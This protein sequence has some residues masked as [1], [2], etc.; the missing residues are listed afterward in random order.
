M[1]FYKLIKY[2]LRNGFFQNRFRLMAIILLVLASCIDF[3][4]RKNL[5]YHFEDIVPAGTFMDYSAYLLGGIPEFIPG[6]DDS[7]IFP[8]KWFLFHILLLYGT[9]HYFSRDLFSCGITILPRSGNRVLWWLSKCIWNICYVVITYLTSFLAIFIFCAIFG[10]SLSLSITPDFM[11]QLMGAR[12]PFTAFPLQF[13]A[14][15]LFLPLFISIGNSLAQMLLTL[16]IR[17][18]FSFVTLAALLLCGAYLNYGL[19][20]STYAMPLR[21]KWIAENGFSFIHGTVVSGLV[22]A[23]AVFIGCIRF[24]RYSILDID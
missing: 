21:S 1:K 19:F 4:A 20:W 17:P 16:F 5:A 3:Y 11:N 8:V 23:A 12:T 10:E 7:F 22:A 18:M 24:Q 2:D 9:L 13:S 15:I 6:L 14:L